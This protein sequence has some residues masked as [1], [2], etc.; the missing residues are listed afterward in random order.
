[1]RP[2]V[3]L[4][5]PPPEP[6]ARARTDAR[7]S[8]RNHD[9]AV[10]S[11]PILGLTSGYIQRSA[12]LLPK[13]GSEHPWKVHQ[14]YLRDYRAPQDERH[15]RL[16]HGVLRSRRARR[17]PVDPWPREP[18][19]PRDSDEG[20]QRPVAAIT[21]AGSGIGRALATQLAR[22]G[23][24]L[25]LSATSTTPAWPRR[26]QQCEG[27]ASRSRRST[28]TSPSGTPSYAWADRVVAEH[29][30]G[31]PH[32]QQCRRGARRHGRGHVLRGLRVADE[33]QLLGRGLRH[34]GVP[35]TSRRQSGEGHIVNLS[36]VFG[37]I[38]VPSQSAYNAAKFAVRGFT[39]TLRMELEIEGSRRVGDDRPPGRDQDQHR[40]QCPHG[41]QRGRRRRRSREGDRGT[42]SA[43]SSPVP[44]KSRAADP[45]RRAPRSPARAGRP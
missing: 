33:Y 26:W 1:M 27:S 17:Q 14:S 10:A 39:D 34:Q 21:G 20:V 41:C 2:H 19:N 28:S 32:R 44:E 30:Q 35:P 40:A 13:Q 7:A 15:R 31:Q 11:G 43:C 8:P 25:A 9:G 37:L 42:S 16:H 4:R 12:H 45:H 36:S 24:H 38:S 29:G 5:V 18:R 23:A 3:R 6:H 22:Q